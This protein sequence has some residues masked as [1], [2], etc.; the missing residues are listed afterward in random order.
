MPVS[1]R[2]LHSFTVVVRDG[3]VIAVEPASTDPY[4][5]EDDI[6]AMIHCLDMVTVEAID[7]DA[8]VA[9]VQARLAAAS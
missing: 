9:E 3:S 6:D 5:N 8:A 1:L 4:V 7:A 2:K